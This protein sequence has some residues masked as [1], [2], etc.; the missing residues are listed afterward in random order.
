MAD[1]CNS[2]KDVKVHSGILTVKSPLRKILKRYGIEYKSFEGTVVDVE[3]DERPFLEKLG[4]DRYKNRCA[5]CCGFLDKSNVEI[6]ALTCNALGER[7]IQIVDTKLGETSH[8]YYAFNSGFDMA[9]LSKLLGRDIR[10]DRELQQ[11]ERQN[12]GYLRQKLGI[13]NFDDPFNDLG[14]L[15]AKEWTKHL[16]TREIDCVKRIVAHN[17]ACVL[18]EYSILVRAGYRVIETNSCKEFFKGRKEIVFGKHQRL[19]E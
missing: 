6:I 2:L 4:A 5:V 8:P 11:Y 1:I 9:L 3:S 18:K 15:A 17:H 19:F 12:K 7:F 13:P 14:K 10:F 16:E